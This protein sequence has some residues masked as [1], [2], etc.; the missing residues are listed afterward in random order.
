MLYF[1]NS[2]LNV[3]ILY[4][5][6]RR[7]MNVTSWV[8]RCSKWTPI[9]IKKTNPSFIN[10]EDRRKEEKRRSWHWTNIWPRV[11][12][13]PDA[14]CERAGIKFLLLLLLRDSSVPNVLSSSWGVV[15]AVTGLIQLR[16]NNSRDR[17]T[18]TRERIETW[19]TEENKWS[20]CDE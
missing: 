3:Y 14:R 10:K 19:S 7:K 1:V 12:A 13:G 5:I 8:L 11:P 15:N 9:Y 2:V 18:R 17:S 20:A 16:L 6:P 4:S